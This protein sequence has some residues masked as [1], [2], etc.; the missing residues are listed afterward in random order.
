MRTTD[1][2]RTSNLIEQ[3]LA[4]PYR[5]EFFQAVR[6]LERYFRQFDVRKPEQV[7][8]S[9]IFFRNSIDLTFPASEIEHAQG[10]IKILNNLDGAEI[11]SALHTTEYEKIELIPKMIG[12]LGSMG[13][14]P[15]FYSERIL[16]REIFYRDRG[17]HAF[18]DIFAN[19]II[20]LFYQSW[21]KYR[22]EFHYELDQRNKFLPLVLSLAG[23]GTEKVRDKL[24]DSQSKI[25]DE[26][27]AFYAA[28]AWQRPLSAVA[29][30]QLLSEYF[31]VPIQIEQFVGRWYAMPCAEYTSLRG[32]AC[33]GSTAFAGTRVWQ[34]DLRVRI[35]LG[36][37]TRKQ[38]EMFLPTSEGARALEKLLL[39]LIGVS[40]EFEVRLKLRGDEVVPA[41]LDHR[42]A[43]RL[44]LNTFM[45]ATAGGPD[46]ADTFYE[47]HTIPQAEVA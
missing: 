10:E 22:L 34:R 47:L 42:N 15:L 2:P 1:R 12:F 33:L 5:F 43:P 9:R 23:L 19:R 11:E 35:W 20:A 18:L 46:R 24:Q 25:F 30:Q 21:K 36:P 27:I 16:E 29:M 17:A 7:L 44:G 28:L 38:F 31:Q 14:L 8:A 26:S 13:V 39:L 4:E 41:A 32:T 3:L 37:L 40:F 6:L 45:Q